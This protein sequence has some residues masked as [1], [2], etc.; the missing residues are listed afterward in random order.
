MQIK[1]I[2]IDRA[3]RLY[4][5][6]PDLM[7]FARTDKARTFLKRADL[8]DLATFRWPIQFD[9]NLSL[10]PESLQPAGSQRIAE[11]KEELATWLAKQCHCNVNSDR[12]IFVGGGIS[13]LLH[14]IAMSY[15]DPGDVA[16]VPGLCIPTYRR[17]V[18]ACNGEPIG[19]SVSS[20]S[21][22][23]PSFERLNTR[24]GRVA[25]LL[26]LNSPHNP[27]GAELSQKDFAE[28]AWL[29][30]RE[31]ILIVNDAAYAGVSTRTPVSLLSVRGGTRV[32]VELHSFS[33]LFGLPP[34]PFGFAVGNR[35][36]LAGMALTRKLARVHIPGYW[37]DAALEAIRSFPN[38]N[39][40]ELR[41]SIS[42]TSAEATGLLDT[43]QLESVGSGSVPYIWAKIN[44]RAMS[45][46]TARQYF[47]RHRVLMIPGSGFGETGEGYL[48]LCLTAGEGAFS[49]AAKRVSKRMTLR[50][51]GTR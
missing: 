2:I 18:N 33:Y 19:Y 1:K 48:R 20:K 23:M 31:N 39:L 12:E 21:D 4:Q 9:D 46:N 27:T 45:V 28:L 17:V 43:M 50:R 24:L 51:K 7:A 49:E 37:V 8:I 10:S 6:P 15:I 16:F 40:R 44:K 47:K 29:A 42:R 34:L 26:F 36:V 5:M 35:E 14:Q 30:G 11:L 25:R 13:T 22:W 32:G 38:D 41:T 3:N